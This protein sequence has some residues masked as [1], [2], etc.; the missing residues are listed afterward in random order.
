MHLAILVLA[1]GLSFF[2]CAYDDGRVRFSFRTDGFELGS[3]GLT[4]QFSDGDRTRVVRKSDFRAGAGGAVS[5][6]FRTGRSGSLS[7]DVLLEDADGARLGSGRVLLPLQDDWEWLVSVVLSDRNPAVDCA[8]CAGVRAFP[9]EP[10][11][12]RSPADSLFVIWSG[13]SISGPVGL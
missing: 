8:R 13:S 11:L 1:A 9:L 12:A 7:V 2:T 3:G 5:E 10:D 4:I 6:V